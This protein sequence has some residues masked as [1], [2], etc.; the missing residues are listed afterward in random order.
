MDYQNATVNTTTH[1]RNTIGVYLVALASDGPQ[2]TASFPGATAASAPF[3]DEGGAAQAAVFGPARD[4]G[5]LPFGL[6]AHLL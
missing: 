2:L 3:A 5:A 4:D 1:T 6:A